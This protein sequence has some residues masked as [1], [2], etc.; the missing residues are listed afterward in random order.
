[1]HGTFESYGFLP[2]GGSATAGAEAA[3]EVVAAPVAVG[4]DC[5]QKRTDE[6]AVSGDR[7]RVTRV[8]PENF[9]RFYGNVTQTCMTNGAYYEDVL[10]GPRGSEDLPFRV[11]KVRYPLGYAKFDIDITQSYA[12]Q[13]ITTGSLT[14]FHI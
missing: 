13:M 8:N 14:S 9:N 2:A 7:V 1:M 11:W 12:E 6:R 3:V 10:C 5:R 4:A